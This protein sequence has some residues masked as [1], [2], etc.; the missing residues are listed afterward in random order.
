MEKTMEENCELDSDIESLFTPEQLV[1]LQLRMKLEV[2][3]VW[4][5]FWAIICV[6]QMVIIHLQ[7]WLP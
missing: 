3:E 5:W 6:L 1:I 7:I 2:E 4:T